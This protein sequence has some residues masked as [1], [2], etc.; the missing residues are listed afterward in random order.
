MAFQKFNIVTELKKVS[1]GRKSKVDPGVLLRLIADDYLDYL[2][3]AGTH[4][5][6]SGDFLER[7]YGL[8][9]PRG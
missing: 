4:P 5:G 9:D 1:R 3:G 2:E 6:D 7:L 8:E